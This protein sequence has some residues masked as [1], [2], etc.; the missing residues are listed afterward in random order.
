[1]D[2]RWFKNF[3]FRVWELDEL[4]IHQ[5][6]MCVDM[7]SRRVSQGFVGNTILENVHMNSEVSMTV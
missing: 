7:Y 3:G 1:M 6:R 4:I 2:L 5:I